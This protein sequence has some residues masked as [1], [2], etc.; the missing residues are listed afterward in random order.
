MVG[1]CLGAQLISA[2]LGA[3]HCPSPEKEVGVFPIQLTEA[4]LRDEKTQQL[5]AS[6]AVG[7]WHHDMPGLPENS[8]VLATSKGCPRQIIAYTNFVYGL[9]CHM[10]F[11]PELVAMLINA[12]EALLS[13]YYTYSF[14]Q[15]AH[16]ILQYNFAYMNE[17]LSGF[18]DQLIHAYTSF[19]N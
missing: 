4:G 7:H 9:Q 8:R 6:L 17:K 5:G 10:E 13:N 2:A 3:P 14:V 19:K 11:T 16:T 18:L 15:A 12:D 1:V